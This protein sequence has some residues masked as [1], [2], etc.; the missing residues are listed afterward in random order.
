MFYNLPG[1]GLVITDLHSMHPFVM[2]VWM[3]SVL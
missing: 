3:L 1:R 2:M